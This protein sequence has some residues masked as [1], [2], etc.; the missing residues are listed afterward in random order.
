MPKPAI[1]TP[2]RARLHLRESNVYR[3][4][5]QLTQQ[6]FI[7]ADNL[8]DYHAI[9]FMIF[10]GIVLPGEIFHPSLRGYYL[11]FSLNPNI[12]QIPHQL[13]ARKNLS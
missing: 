3:F 1:G 4:T 10:K 5:E 2:E 7:S 8:S 11:P 6:G 12:S 13:V 9:E